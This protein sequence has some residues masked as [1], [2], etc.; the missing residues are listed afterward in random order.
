MIDK[1]QDF[2][3]VADTINLPTGVKFTGSSD[4]SLF[5]G[6]TLHINDLG[7]QVTETQ[8]AF[9]NSTDPSEKKALQNKLVNLNNVIS[10]YRDSIEKKNPNSILTALFK[11]MKEPIVPPASAHPGGKY[12]SNFA[13]RYFKTNYWN[14]ISFTDDRMIRTPIFEQK[15][16]KYYKDLV[17]PDPDSINR[18]VDHMLL[19]SRT[20]P[21][22]FKYLMVFFVQKYINPE[23]MGQ[24]AVFVHLF[25]KYINTGQAEFFTEQYKKI[26]SDRAY[27]LMANL[28]GNPAS[29][30]D[31]VDSAGKQVQLYDVQA[32]FTIVCFW[33]PECSHC[34]EVVPKLDSIYKAKWKNQNVKLFGV[35]VDGTRDAWLKFIHENNLKD[36]I[37]V[38]Q[39]DAQRDAD[40]KANRPNYRQ[41]YDV[42]QTPIL[43]LLD[44]EK[45]IIAKKLS[46]Q[47]VD[48]VMNIKRKKQNQ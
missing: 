47:Q 46:Y 45:R 12:D 40:S 30:L 10:K 22:M 28:I 26:M 2:S 6:Y 18:E 19:M 9:R 42:Y 25:E 20:S 21:E 36:W 33:D 32:E 43:Y 7:L 35:K 23:Y 14:G 8:Q 15:L 27:S 37:H 11:G 3:I 29:N 17:A 48:E 5:Y 39:T 1:Q 16:E 41:L 38:Y 24:D 44:K 13:Y 31:M 4:N 34:K